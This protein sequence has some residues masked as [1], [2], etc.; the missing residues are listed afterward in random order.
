VFGVEA[1][2]WRD[3]P[4]EYP[5]DAPPE[6]TGMD[7]VVYRGAAAGPMLCGRLAMTADFGDVPSH[8][9]IYFNVEDADSAADRVVVGGGRVVIAPFDTPYGRMTVVS[10]SNG[11]VLGLSAA[12]IA[13]SRVASWVRT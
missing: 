8:W 6:Q 2:A 11:A 9:I 5:G 1:V 12:A 13:R 7:Y 10:D 4:E 3:I